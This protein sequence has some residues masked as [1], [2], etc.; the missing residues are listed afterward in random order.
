MRTNGRRKSTHSET[1]DR[2]DEG[3]Q[4]TEQRDT[5]NGEAAARSAPQLQFIDS[6]IAF[7]Y[8][9][10]FIQVFQFCIAVVALPRSLF[11]QQN[12][13][14]S[15][16]QSI[17]ST[18]CARKNPQKEKIVRI[19]PYRT[20]PVLVPPFIQHQHATEKSQI[21]RCR[22]PQY[23]GRHGFLECLV[24]GNASET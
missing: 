24:S 2:E 10:Y 11:L 8:R 7:A 15:F 3:R 6:E 9:L 17:D 20:V 22:R 16:F 18:A 5:T 4:P 1:R 13:S 14:F 19:I 21:Q 12:S 23:Q